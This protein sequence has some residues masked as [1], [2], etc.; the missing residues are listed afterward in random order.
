MESRFFTNTS[1]NLSSD[2][3]PKSS[4]ASNAANYM[5]TYFNGSSN[6]SAT[7]GNSS[8]SLVVVN[9]NESIYSQ[10]AVLSLIN[11]QSKTRSYI[12]SLGGN[13]SFLSFIELENSSLHALANATKGLDKFTYPLALGLQSGLRHRIYNFHQKLK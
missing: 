5:S 4:M 6:S 3:V 8:S 13:V 1:Y 2:I 12:E 11:A 9:T 7:N 10:P